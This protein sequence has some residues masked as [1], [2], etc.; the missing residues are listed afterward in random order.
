MFLRVPGRDPVFSR[1]SACKRSYWGGLVEQARK[2]RLPGDNKHMGSLSIRL[3]SAASHHE[4]KAS[5]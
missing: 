5:S 3:T 4:E 1:F 2:T